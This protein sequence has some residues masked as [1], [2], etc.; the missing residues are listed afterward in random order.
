ME[1]A[2]DPIPINTKYNQYIQ[3][4]NAFFVFYFFL[5]ASVLSSSVLPYHCIC[6]S[7]V[8]VFLAALLT[9]LNFA[10]VVVH[11]LLFIHVAM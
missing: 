5:A 8:L 1:N 4:T 2:T 9:Q 7:F 6:V 10:Y 11:M 3:Y